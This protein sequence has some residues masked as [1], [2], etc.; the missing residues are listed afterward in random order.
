MY[1]KKN[2]AY[3]GCEEFKR[4]SPYLPVLQAVALSHDAFHYVV[5][6]NAPIDCVVNKALKYSVLNKV[7]KKCRLWLFWYKM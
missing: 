6:Y 4:P 5:V 2:I 1:N 3:R 7:F